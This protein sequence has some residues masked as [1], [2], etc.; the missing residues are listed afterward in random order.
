YH[1]D[2]RYKSHKNVQLRHV[3]ITS[4]HISTI[5]T[6]SF[7]Q[8]YQTSHS[9]TSGLLTWLPAEQPC[10]QVY[11]KKTSADDGQKRWTGETIIQKRSSRGHILQTENATPKCKTHEL[12]NFLFKRNL[13][14]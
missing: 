12:K 4:T 2:S 6:L 3:Y 5:S 9:F 10:G 8:R 1:R 7:L 11:V 13:K 14:I